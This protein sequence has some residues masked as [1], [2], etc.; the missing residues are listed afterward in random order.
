MI[1][2]YKYWRG[3]RVYS[4]TVHILLPADTEVLLKVIHHVIKNA[5]FIH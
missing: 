2:M 3:V 4:N 5:T 1:Y